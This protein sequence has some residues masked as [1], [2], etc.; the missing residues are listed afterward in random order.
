MRRE[1]ELWGVLASLCVLGTV[2]IANGFPQSWI[3]LW[4]AAISVIPVAVFLFYLSE[5]ALDEFGRW[6]H[7][8][9]HIEDAMSAYAASLN[10]QLDGLSREIEGLK[11]ELEETHGK[12]RFQARGRRL[13]SR[14]A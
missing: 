13:I 4:P 8:R 1:L 12:V 3:A 2:L 14:P 5:M 6:M 9:R 7:S 10:L 11:C